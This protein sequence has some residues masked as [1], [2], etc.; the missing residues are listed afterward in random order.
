MQAA[1]YPPGFVGYDDLQGRVYRGNLRRDGVF[2]TTGISKAKGIKW[3]FKTGKGVKSS[4]IVVDGVLYVGSDDKSFYAINAETGEKIWSFKTEAPVISSAAV[5]G[6]SV[7]FISGKKIYSLDAKTGKQNWSNTFLKGGGFGSVAVAYGIVF[8]PAGC[9]RGVFN[10]T[11]WGGFS[12]KGFDVITGKKVWEQE[13][14][15]PQGLSS[16]IIHDNYLIYA[17]GFQAMLVDLFKG[18][19]I[20]VK[21]RKNKI[22]NWLGARSGWSSAIVDTPALSDGYVFDTGCYGADQHGMPLNGELKVTNLKTGKKQ[23]IIHPYEGTDENNK[24][25]KVRD[26]K[27]HSIHTA[28]TVFG[29]C[30]FLADGVGIVRSMNYKTKKRGWKFQ[31]GGAV[32]SSLSYANG[33]VYFGCNDGNVY[34][35][36]AKTGTLQWKIKA[37]T[38]FVS[39][40]YIGDGVIYI[41]SEDGNIIAI[42]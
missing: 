2:K 23:W 3:S 13:G 9:R 17:S 4:P 7:F 12:M 27:D 6:G 28:P 30:V 10:E 40:P 11:S 34:A 22:V 31:A 20:K 41:G 36:D 29:D 39:S 19:F 24:K 18:E 5:V 15:G 1:D 8:A 35:L 42:Q 32:K 16:P 37:G 38:E 21:G 14:A 25:E 33:I 26:G